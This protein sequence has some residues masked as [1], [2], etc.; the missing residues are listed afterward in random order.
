MSSAVDSRVILDCPGAET[1]LGKGDMF[2][3]SAES[4]DLTRVQGALVPD[5]DIA[6]LLRHWSLQISHLQH[7]EQVI[8]EEA[9]PTLAANP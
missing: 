6:R 1:L 7:A 2:L 8:A 3:R 9:P 5:E 4:Q